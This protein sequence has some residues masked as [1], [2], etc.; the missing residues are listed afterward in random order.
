MRLY[1][2]CSFPTIELL[3]ARI[4]QNP[5]DPF[6]AQWEDHAIGTLSGQTGHVYSAW[7]E[8]SYPDGTGNYTAIN[9]VYEQ[10]YGCQY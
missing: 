10:D 5:Y 4:F 7:Q 1:S 3:D 8:C 2:T 6:I 9:G